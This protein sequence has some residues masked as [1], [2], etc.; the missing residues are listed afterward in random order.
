MEHAP[1]GEGGAVPDVLPSGDRSMSVPERILPVPLAQYLLLHDPGVTLQRRPEETYLV[2]W[3]AQ[4]VPLTPPRITDPVGP[5]LCKPLSG[6]SQAPI[7]GT[8]A[9]FLDIRSHVETH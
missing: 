1:A 5:T 3:A 7:K 2:P 8:E 4:E 6:N 9:Q